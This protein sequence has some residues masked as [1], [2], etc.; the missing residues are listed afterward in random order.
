MDLKQFRLSKEGILPS[1]IVVG[2][3]A[4]GWKYEIKDSQDPLRISHGMFAKEAGKR[5]AY[6]DACKARGAVIYD[7]KS[8]NEITVYRQSWMSVNLPTMTAMGEKVYHV[9]EVFV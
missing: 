5:V 1:R 4:G 6:Q 3:T 8:M 7:W 9:V 2:L